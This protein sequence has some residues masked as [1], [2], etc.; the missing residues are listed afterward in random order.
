MMCA[1]PEAEDPPGPRLP[2]FE[3]NVTGGTATVVLRGEFDA[4]SEDL[5]AGRLERIRQAGA[6][7]LIFDAARVDFMDCASARLIAGTGRWLPAGTK[8]I[9]R[10]PSPVVGTVLEVTGIGSLCELELPG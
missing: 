3:A 6:R 10:S 5:L 4:T 7:R 2:V 1:G 9:I 8:P